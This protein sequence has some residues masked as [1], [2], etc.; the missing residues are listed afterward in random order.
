MW[1]RERI[2]P[3][4][5]CKLIQA[6]SY[7][8]LDVFSCSAV[9][10]SLQLHGLQILPEFAQTHIHWIDDAI[11]PSH[12]LSSPSPWALNLSEHQALFQWVGSSSGGQ[13]IGASASASALPMNIQYW[14]PLGLTGSICEYPFCTALTLRIEVWFHK[15]QEQ[16]INISQDVW[17]TQNAIQIITNNLTVLQMNNI[18]TLWQRKEL[19]WIASECN[20]LNG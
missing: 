5:Y 1:T 20:I 14:F 9:S 11:Q 12:L 10:D 8:R 2:C 4:G 6:S 18:T 7:T 16:I 13:S 17:R 3:V 15:P 19:T